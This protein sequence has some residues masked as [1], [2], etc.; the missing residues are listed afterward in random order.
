MPR[1]LSLFLSFQAA[2]GARL[3][4]IRKTKETAAAN[5]VRGELARV[6]TES[7]GAPPGGARGHEK[8]STDF[9]CPANT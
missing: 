5:T 2:N 9:S 6:K 1:L 4:G 8:G 3:G 7:T